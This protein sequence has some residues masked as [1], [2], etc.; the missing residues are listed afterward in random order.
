MGIGGPGE[1][2]RVLIG[3]GEVAVDSGLEIDDALEDA[4]FEPLPG[5]L[6]EKTLDGIEP[7]GRGRGE[8]E[9]EPGM[10]FEPGPHLRMLMRRIVVDDQVQLSAGRGFAVDLVEEADEFLMPVARHA[11]ADDPALQY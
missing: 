8:M 3:F 6:G 9:V 1:G 10:P 7:G 11:L 5:Q 4:A 2:F